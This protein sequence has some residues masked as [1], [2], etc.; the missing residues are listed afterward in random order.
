MGS[1]DL[2]QLSLGPS[3]CVHSGVCWT[4]KGVGTARSCAA[5]RHFGEF[6]YSSSSARKRGQGCC[7]PY[8]TCHWHIVTNTSR[9]SN[10]LMGQ[11]A[12]LYNL[13]PLRS[14]KVFVNGKIYVKSNYEF[15]ANRDLQC[16]EVQNK[17]QQHKQ[18]SSLHIGKEIS[19]FLIYFLSS[20]GLKYNQELVGTEKDSEIFLSR[21]CRNQNPKYICSF[22]ISFIWKAWNLLYEGIL[23]I[24]WVSDVQSLRHNFLLCPEHVCTCLVSFILDHLI[25]KGGVVF[26]C[27]EDAAWNTTWL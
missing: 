10:A 26:S 27:T 2:H 3:V 20:K 7:R 5:H 15:H 9:S 23:K 17:E 24:I 21:N 4:C 14:L 18:K 13:Q 19:V 8:P 11:P 1:T 6:P 12:F 22:G 25:F 16:P